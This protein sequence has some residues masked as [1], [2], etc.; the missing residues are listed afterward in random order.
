MIPKRSENNCKTCVIQCLAPR[1]RA[2]EKEEGDT[3]NQRRERKRGCQN[4]FNNC[5]PEKTVPAEGIGNR[6]GNGNTDE[7]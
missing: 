3:R 2:K 6:N 7:G 4:Q 5:F 1:C